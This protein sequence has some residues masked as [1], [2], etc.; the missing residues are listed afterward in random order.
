MFPYIFASLS[1]CMNME[2]GIFGSQR[3]VMIYCWRPALPTWSSGRDSKMSVLG[4]FSTAVGIYVSLISDWSEKWCRVF[5]PAN[6]P[7]V[8]AQSAD[9][10]FF[11]SMKLQAGVSPGFFFPAATLITSP[12]WPPLYVSKRATTQ[13]TTY[14]NFLGLNRFSQ[15]GIIKIPL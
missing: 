11:F 1:I 4:L 3:H 15:R 9:F 2:H 5:M 6:Q 12:Y 8:Q 7:A 13:F 10:F 14:E